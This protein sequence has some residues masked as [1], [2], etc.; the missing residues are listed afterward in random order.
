MRNYVTDMMFMINGPGDLEANGRRLFQAIET[1][2]EVT[3]SGL[4]ASDCLVTWA[5]STG[6]FED[7]KFCASVNGL[8][9]E[10]NQYNR[11]I[12]GTVWRKHLLCWAA[13]YCLG[14][15]G[16]YAELGCYTGETVKM[17]IDY[18]DFSTTEK[19]YWLYDMFED[20]GVAR[21]LLPQLSDGLYQQTVAKF[22]DTPRVKIIKGRVPD[23]FEQ[24]KPKKIALLH[25]DMNNAG[26]ERAALEGLYDAVEKAGVIIFDDYGWVQYRAQKD[27]ADEFMRLHGKKIFEL[28]TGQ[29]LVIK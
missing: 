19:T 11:A 13:D 14:V 17:I 7:D 6:F 26:A 23:A 22:A 3:A 21:T 15:E 16:D 18:T 29:G 28:P 4:F 9:T 8:L 5:K 1:I 10:N 2:R 24:G 12:L 20:D 27:S 25:I